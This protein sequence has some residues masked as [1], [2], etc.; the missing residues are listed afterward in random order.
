V[1]D[2][3]Q[4]L[5]RW[6]Q[7]D[8]AIGLD[9]ELAEVRV[10][11]AARDAEI[12]DVRQRNERL[13]QRVAQLVTERDALARQVATLQTPSVSGRVYRRAR[14]TAGRLLRPLRG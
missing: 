3:D 7:R 9:A 2:V 11:L 13:A 6:A 12:A 14:S 10:A 5:A 1:S 8:A 4:T